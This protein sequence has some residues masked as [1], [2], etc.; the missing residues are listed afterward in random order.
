MLKTTLCIVHQGLCRLGLFFPRIQHIP[1]FPSPNEL[2]QSQHA[3]LSLYK[4]FIGVN[5]SFE[6]IWA[7]EVTSRFI[8]TM[9][10]AKLG[11]NCQQLRLDERQTEFVHSKHTWF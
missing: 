5:L 3:W 1:P 8:S 7:V 9:I 6:N 2:V 4:M 10:R 11:W